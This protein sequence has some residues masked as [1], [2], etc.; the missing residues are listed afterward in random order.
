MFKAEEHP[1]MTQ[2]QL[3]D[4]H[5][6]WIDTLSPEFQV[7]KMGKTP[8][9]AMLEGLGIKPPQTPQ[10]TRQTPPRP[11]DESPPE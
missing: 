9:E 6:R 1:E 11:H 3:R 10:E 7:H 5:N 2:E 8:Y 4:A